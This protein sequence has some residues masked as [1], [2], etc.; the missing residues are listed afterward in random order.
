[1]I[2]KIKYWCVSDTHFGH[3]MLVKND[4]RKKGFEEDILIDILKNISAGDIVIHLGDVSFYD[5]GGWNI[6]FTEMCWQIGCKCWLVLG[7]HDKKTNTWY[8]N[9]G[10]DFV[11]MSMQLRLFGLDLVFTHEP[12]IVDYS[13]KMP[14]SFNIHGH[15]H[16]GRECIQHPQNLLVTHNIVNLKKLVGK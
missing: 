9:H 11:G 6:R 13:I 16:D 7:N 12:I 14:F 10:W 3:D 2:Q 15:I 8:L 1:M 5:H 4:H